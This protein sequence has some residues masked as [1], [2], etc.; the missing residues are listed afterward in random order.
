M[1]KTI[2][3]LTVL[4]KRIENLLRM[5]FADRAVMNRMRPVSDGRSILIAAGS[6][7]AAEELK[8]LLCRS[9]VDICAVTENVDQAV[10]ALG[11][12]RP[13]LILF[14]TGLMISSD[15]YMTVLDKA[16]AL[17]I[18]VFYLINGDDEIELISYLNPD[19]WILK[20]SCQEDELY[21]MICELFRLKGKAAKVSIYLPVESGY[22][23]P[24]PVISMAE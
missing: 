1:K 8:M 2:H 10:N 4:N 3:R 12:C 21:D 20:K 9:G 15:Q 14:D 5:K 17:E 13:G 23:F 16:G 22:P 24:S 18:P 11:I 7:A 6:H 19:G